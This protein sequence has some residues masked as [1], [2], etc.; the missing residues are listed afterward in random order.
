M[1]TAVYN[2]AKSSPCPL[3]FHMVTEGA[4]DIGGGIGCLAAA[5]L[6][7][8]GVPL[9]FTLLT[10]LLGA[11]GTLFFLR[12]YYAAEDPSSLSASQSADLIS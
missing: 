8:A 1:A 4:Y 10:S 5:G 3:R 2:L 6:I 12:R 9:R 11:A 7:V